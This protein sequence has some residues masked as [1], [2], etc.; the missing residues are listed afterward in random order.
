MNKNKLANKRERKN[1]K[2]K[3]LAAHR[4]RVGPMNYY[5][6]RINII[7]TTCGG[8][9]KLSEMIMKSSSGASGPCR[10]CI[11]RM[12]KENEQKENKKD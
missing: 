11:N 4:R 6:D 8:L 1:L 10:F 3:K 9:R 12:V 5:A 2:R 7:C